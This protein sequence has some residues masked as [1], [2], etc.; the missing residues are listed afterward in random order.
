MRLRAKKTRRIS[1]DEYRR[2]MLAETSRFIEWGLKHP[3]LVI[4]IPAKPVG[5][6]GFPKQ[7]GEWFWGVVL[8]VDM[9]S[10]VR[11][12]RDFLLR[13]P[14]GLLRRLRS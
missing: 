1:W 14:A 12:W 3:E 2:Q 6:G 9:N 7:V 10:R 11:R 5:E 8:T 13:R 4:E